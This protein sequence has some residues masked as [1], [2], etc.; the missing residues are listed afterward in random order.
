MSPLR[1]LP[2]VPDDADGAEPPAIVER[3]DG[4]YWVSGE[5]GAE[6]GPFETYDLAEADR[7]AGGTDAPEPGESLLEAEDEI[8]INEWLDSETGA[9]AEGHSPPHLADD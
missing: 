4:Y 2:A 5:S 9:P 8:G 1:P 7:D 6:V 3:P